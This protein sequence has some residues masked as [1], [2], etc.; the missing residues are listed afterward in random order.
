MGKC[1]GGMRVIGKNEE[2]GLYF[3]D[4]ASVH[5]TKKALVDAKRVLEIP[6]HERSSFL[7]GLNPVENVW[8]IL[9]QRI[10]RSR[11]LST[12]SEMKQAVQEE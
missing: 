8:R 1:G 11:F 10:K 12:L 7:P 5:G 4:H 9:K 2:W 6:L 3:G